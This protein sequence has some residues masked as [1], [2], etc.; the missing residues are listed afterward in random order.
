M[1]RNLFLSITNFIR[2]VERLFLP[3]GGHPPALALAGFQHEHSGLS[4]QKSSQEFSLKQLIG[5]GIFWAVP[6]HRRSVE[7]RLKRKFGYPEYV[8]K[9]LREKRNIRSCLQCGHDHE[10]GVLCPFCYQKVLKE[11]E[12]MQEKIQENLGLDP[13][14]KEVIVLYEGEKAEQ[15]AEELKG[16]RIVEMKKPRPMWFTKNLLQ[17]STQQLSETKEV[18]PSDLA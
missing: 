15:S 4:G 3:H 5:D 9:P 1:S 14:D 17:K 8:W 13:V 6:K 11:T 7:K 16:K 2:N 18:K 10:L 12:L